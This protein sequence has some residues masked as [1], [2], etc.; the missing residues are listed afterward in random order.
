MFA[1]R[2]NKWVVVSL[3]FAGG[4]YAETSQGIPDQFARP[5]DFLLSDLFPEYRSVCV[6]PE[7]TR[8]SK[9]ALDN[10][11][12]I[13]VDAFVSELESFIILISSSGEVTHEMVSATS[14]GI[15]M[16]FQSSGCFLPNE[17][18][19][20]IKNSTTPIGGEF[21]KIQINLE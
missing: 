10:N 1:S 18:V 21:Y 16:I 12:D 8:F 6:V 17:N 3:L 13:N 9:F 7:Y 14:D 20:S 2:L 4:S 5:G 19:I 11:I 15:R